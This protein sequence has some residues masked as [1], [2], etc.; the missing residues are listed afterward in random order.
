MEPPGAEEVELAFQADYG[1]ARG[2]H[3]WLLDSHKV[4]ECRA[5]L[6]RQ[7]AKSHLAYSGAKP[8]V[9]EFLGLLCREQAGGRE[10]VRRR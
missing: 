8:S 5:Y 1:S 6:E 2:G 9:E 7:E 4:P 3:G 10:R